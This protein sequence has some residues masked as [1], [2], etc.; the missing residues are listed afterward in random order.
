MIH[1][2]K[3]SPFRVNNVED[4]VKQGESVDVDVIEIDKEKGRIG[5]KR[6]IPAEEMARFEESKKPKE[7]PKITLPTTE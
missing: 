1:I 5:L 3:L 7:T 6:V 4:V 2:S